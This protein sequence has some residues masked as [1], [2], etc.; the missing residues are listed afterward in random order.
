MLIKIKSSQLYT[1]ACL[2]DLPPELLEQIFRHLTVQ[3]CLMGIGRVCRRFRS[4]VQCSGDIWKTLETD[5]E[6]SVDA[7]QFVI[8]K[9]AKHFQKLALRFSQKQ[10][11][12]KSPDMYIETILARCENVNSLDLSYNTSIITLNFVSSMI[13]LKYLYL[14]GCTG[15][16][17]I[18]MARYI[19]HCKTLRVIN[20]SNCIQ[21]R[22]EH[23]STLV[24]AIIALPF[25]EVL[26][27]ESTFDCQ[28]TVENASK[29]LQR[30]TLKELAVTPT[31]GP[32]PVWVELMSLYAEHVKFGGDL[33]SQFERINLPNYLYP[34]EQ[35]ELDW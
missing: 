33:M 28:F 4:L 12:Y 13:S 7:F 24:D 15:I 34:D 30:K 17:P 32:P 35:E 25:L 5:A 31:W 10:V 29:L 20:I 22:Y 21:L 3:D 19:K 1:G 2:T 11:R 18:N 6:L 23:I 14:T 8:V 27:A 26:N 16:D 9:H